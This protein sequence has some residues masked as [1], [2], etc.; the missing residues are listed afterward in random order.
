[1]KTANLIYS[2]KRSNSLGFTTAKIA[3]KKQPLEEAADFF[4][5]NAS[6]NS[7]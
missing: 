3:Q 5:G 6:G 7:E 2:E 4:L 1:M